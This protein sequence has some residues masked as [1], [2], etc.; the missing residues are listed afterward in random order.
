MDKDA[1]DYREYGE[2]LIRE[3]LNKHNPCHDRGNKVS[4]RVASYL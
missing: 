4:S 1:I 3:D 2:K